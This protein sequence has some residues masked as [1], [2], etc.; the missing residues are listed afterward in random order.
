MRRSEG[1]AARS[2]RGVW[3]CAT[4]PMCSSD[5]LC[6]GQ[7]T[8]AQCKERFEALFLAMLAETP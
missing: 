3:L 2:R 6:G 5:C 8:A 1:A 4:E 7:L